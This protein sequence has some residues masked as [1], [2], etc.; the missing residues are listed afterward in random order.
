M[1]IINTIDGLRA[2]CRVRPGRGVAAGAE[3][4]GAHE[5]QERRVACTPAMLKLAVVE[6]CPVPNKCMMRTSPSTARGRLH[7]GDAETVEVKAWSLLDFSSP[8]L[9]PK[10]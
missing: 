8:L 2:H 3:M 1:V 7:P 6:P 5:L 10:R 9:Q 4:G